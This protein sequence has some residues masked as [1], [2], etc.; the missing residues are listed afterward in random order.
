MQNFRTINNDEEE[1]EESNE[2]ISF[3]R[4]LERISTIVN[5]KEICSLLS[6]S[7]N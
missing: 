3:R 7:L 1:K 4:H 6:L 5:E 2:E